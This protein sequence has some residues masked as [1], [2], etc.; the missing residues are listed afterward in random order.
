MNSTVDNSVVT[1]YDVKKIL[2]NFFKGYIQHG[3]S[4]TIDVQHFFEMNIL[5][6]I[7]A[8]K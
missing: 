6:Q 1:N 3:Y 5:S 4:D 2:L 8:F 7:K